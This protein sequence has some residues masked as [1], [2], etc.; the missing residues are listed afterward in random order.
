MFILLS[1]IIP[2]V[3][4]CI[5]CNNAMVAAQCVILNSLGVP[6]MF[7]DIQAQAVV[8]Q[9]IPISF[10]G[11]KVAWFEGGQAQE[12]LQHFFIEP[13]SGYQNHQVANDL[14]ERS[15]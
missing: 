7:Q 11:M 5:E 15:A 10:A 2:T 14:W 9:S 4:F 8:L 3:Y 13:S 12:V 6:L 1:Q